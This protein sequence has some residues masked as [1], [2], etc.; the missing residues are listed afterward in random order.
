MTPQ[1]GH[2][3]RGI[4]MLA[5]AQTSHIVAR[6]PAWRAGDVVCH[7]VLQ[8]LIARDAQSVALHALRPAVDVAQPVQRLGG[9]MRAAAALAL[10]CGQVAR[11]WGRAYVPT[12]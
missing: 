11:W 5:C 6:R 4:H 12:C 2:G 8:L 9:L 3:R 10:D 1:E 7:H